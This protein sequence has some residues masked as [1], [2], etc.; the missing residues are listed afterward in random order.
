MVAGGVIVIIGGISVAWLWVV[1]I[2]GTIVAST[3]RT[4]D[5]VIATIIR[6]MSFP[7]MAFVMMAVMRMPVIMSVIIMVMV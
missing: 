7:V 5:L 6:L 2:V 4:V 1:V 3:W